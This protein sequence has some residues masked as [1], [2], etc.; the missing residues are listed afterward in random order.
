RPVGHRWEH[1]ATEEFMGRSRTRI[2]LGVALFVVFTGATGPLQAQAPSDSPPLSPTPFSTIDRTFQGPEEEAL[3]E[4][5]LVRQFYE[6]RAWRPAWTDAAGVSPAAMDFLD[7]LR[8]V[9]TEG[10]FPSDYHLQRLETLSARLSPSASAPIGQAPENRSRFEWLMTDTF[11]HCGRHLSNGRTGYARGDAPG[12]NLCPDTDLADTLEKALAE[13]RV[14][15]ALLDFSPRH[16]YFLRLRAALSRYRGIVARGGWPVIPP[17]PTLRRGTQGPEVSLIRQRLAAEEGLGEESTA[18]PED[19]DTRLEED[20]KRFQQRHGLKASGAVDADTRQAMSVPAADRLALIELNLERWRW[21]CRQLGDDYLLVNIPDFRLRAVRDGFPVLEL[22][23]VVGQTRPEWQTPEFNSLL[24]QIVFHPFWVVP[25][26][27]ATRE[28]LP[29]IKADPDYLKRQRL[30]V[31]R[32]ARDKTG[33]DPFE[34]AW[35]SLS[36]HHFP[37]TLRQDPGAGNALGQIKFVLTNTP[38]IYLHDTPSKRHFRRHVRTFSH[39]CVRVEKPLA[40]VRHLFGDT[41]ATEKLIREGLMKKRPTTINLPQ[42]VLVYLVYV[43]SW[44]EADGNVH[45]RPDVYG[46]DPLLSALLREPRH[47]F[48]SFEAAPPEG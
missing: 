41:P 15:E 16:G 4:S 30:Q 14:G 21:L 38:D 6:N 40:L 33:L 35:E 17:G 5:A 26:S 19:F 34:I 12:A 48:P 13:G 25:R 9:D 45:F 28:M 31:V 37:Y 18:T 42:P 20:V 39:G 46:R 3:Y 8:R 11:L 24:S 23:V 29:K 7:T 22:R 2:F 10:L 1:P 27:I 32:S 44:A 43:T 47:P 36:V